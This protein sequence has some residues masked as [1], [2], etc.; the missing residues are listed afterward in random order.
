MKKLL[1]LLPIA[2]CGACSS[3]EPVTPEIEPTDY[4]LTDGESRAAVEIQNFNG[5]FFK[6]C[7]SKF[8]AG[9]NMVCSPF[10]ASVLLSM[11]ANGGDDKVKDQITEALGCSDIEALN[12]LAFKQL[13]VLP[14]AEKS[15]Q[16]LC[17]NALWYRNQLSLRDNYATVMKS[18]YGTDMF[19]R[20]FEDVRPL[21]AEMNQWCYENTN[22][23]I[24]EFINEIDPNAVSVI[25]NTL[26]F[27]GSWAVPFDASKT[28]KAYFGGVDG[29]SLVDMMYV[30]NTQHFVEGDN[31]SAVRMQMGNGA[32]EVSV[33]LPNE[34]VDFDSFIADFDFAGYALKRNND[35]LVDYY[36]PRF[37]FTSDQMG[38]TDVLGGMGMTALNEIRPSSI[39]NESVEARHDIY[40]RT[41]MEF[42]EQG[43][44]GAAITW[45]SPVLLPGDGSEPEIKRFC[46]DRPFIFTL[47]AT[48]TGAMLFA[49]RMVRF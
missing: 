38:I 1:F 46:V 27:K 35:V 8:D 44:E 22:G 16:M 42:T 17:A 20:D 4:E 40:Q 15:S 2:I 41:G 28:E 11:I 19:A 47:T 29:R 13:S 32:F 43:A 26:Y 23:V 14:S 3:D 25:A 12:G 10:S 39:F 45:D 6:A 30:R 36:L 34:G 33:I 18:T 9:E 24:P 37:K 49:G 5:E 21:L 48:K 7:A 31:Y